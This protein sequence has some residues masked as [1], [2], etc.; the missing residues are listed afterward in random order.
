M[1]KTYHRL[2]IIEQRAEL[3]RRH[4]LQFPRRIYRC[5]R[6]N[7]IVDEP[8]ALAHLER[9][10]PLREN[11]DEFSTM[12]LQHFQPHE[13]THI[14]PPEVVKPKRQPPRRPQEIF[15]APNDTV[16]D[17]PVETIIDEVELLPDAE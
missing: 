10:R 17:A 3:R 1:A 14:K 13:L 5:R 7:I 9:C 12:L 2:T 11:P 4:E 8:S 16:V 6:C 15:D